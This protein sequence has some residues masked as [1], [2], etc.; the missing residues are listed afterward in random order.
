MRA[1]QHHTRRSSRAEI[2]VEPTAWGKMQMRCAAEW[3]EPATGYRPI[4]RFDDENGLSRQS[5]SLIKVPGPWNMRSILQSLRDQFLMPRTEYPLRSREA[6]FPSELFS[7]KNELS[8]FTKPMW[9][10]IRTSSDSE[11]ITN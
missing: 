1:T 2:D 7:E 8:Q 3:M 11:P 10:G 5:A 4:G 9:L 6:T